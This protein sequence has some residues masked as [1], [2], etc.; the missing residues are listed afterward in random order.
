MTTQR[1]QIYAALFALLQSALQSPAGPFRTVSRRWQDP[2]QIS[3]ADRPALYQVQKEETARTSV[4]GVPIHWKIGLDLVAYTAGDAEPGVVQSTELNNLL[5]AVE[6]ALQT[7]APGMAQS[8]GKQVNYC[9]IE[10]KV[11]IVENVQGTMA[12]AVIP[13]LIEI[14]A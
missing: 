1:E 7:A 3:P 10:G 12:M 2:A 11:E 5:D 13:I 9:R 8:L 14:T 4:I 6:R